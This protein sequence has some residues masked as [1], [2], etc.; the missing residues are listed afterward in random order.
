MKFIV[1]NT[2]KVD[3]ATVRAVNDAGCVALPGEY[4]IVNAGTLNNAG[5]IQA[6]AGVDGVL[7]DTTG[8]INNTG[9]GFIF[10][11]WKYRSIINNIIV[12]NHK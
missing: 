2:A 4:E 3:G 12:G 7:L 8:I 9:N 6:L 10:N 5:I 1:E 11:E